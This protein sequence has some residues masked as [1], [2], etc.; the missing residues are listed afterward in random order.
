MIGS[1]RFIRWR[2]FLLALLFANGISSVANS[3]AEM[4]LRCDRPDVRT[5]M[6]KIAEDKKRDASIRTLAQMWLVA[7][8]DGGAGPYATGQRGDLDLYQRAWARGVLELRWLPD[9]GAP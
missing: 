1:A 8:K 3:A 7:V 5:S 2:G 6:R 4:L 9:G